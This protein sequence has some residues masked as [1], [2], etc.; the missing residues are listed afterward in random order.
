[1]SDYAQNMRVL[2]ALVAFDNPPLVAVTSDNWQACRAAGYI[3][4]HITSHKAFIK[5]YKK[6]NKIE[7]ETK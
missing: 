7:K 4:D 2:D 5:W 6:L 1:M 3:P